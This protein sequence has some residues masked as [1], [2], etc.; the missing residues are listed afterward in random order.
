MLGLRDR[1]IMLQI[2]R[3]TPILTKEDWENFMHLFEQV[4]PGLS[5]E[6]SER[7]P[8]LTSAE[9]RIVLL[10]KLGLKNMQAASILSVSAE[11]V[12]K[13]RQRLRKKLGED[14]E[15]ARELL[16]E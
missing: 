2:I 9:T 15:A 10:N 14:E 12:K 5:L 13:T 11:A 1:K 7:F 3:S 16:G 4:Y 8:Q 6:L